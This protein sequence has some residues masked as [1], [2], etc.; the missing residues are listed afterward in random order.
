MT[1]TALVTYIVFGL[2]A[3]VGRSWL[4]HRRTGDFGFRAFAQPRGAAAT[5]AAC[6]LAIGATAAPLALLADLLSWPAGARLLESELVRAFGLGVMLIGGTLVVAS[7]VQM[8]ASWRIGVGENERTALVTTGLFSVV[9]H[10]IYSGV[11]VFF[12]GILMVASNAIAIVGLPV[13]VAGLELQVRL[14]EEPNLLR[15]HG[16]DYRSYARRVGRFVPGVGRR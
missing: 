15:V 1:A 13:L 5:I 10:P 6:L 4:Q 3:S 8:G 2:V 11:L 12:V 9:R 16:E 7:Q 14:I